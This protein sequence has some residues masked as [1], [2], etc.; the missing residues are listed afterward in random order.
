MNPTELVHAFLDRLAD[1]EIDRW[2][3]LL[4]DDV[5]ADTPFAPDGSPKGFAGAEAV[6]R[7]FGDARE[8]MQALDFYDRVV[9]ETTDGPVVV[10]CKSTGTRGD[11]QPYKN[12]YCW[13]FSIDTSKITGW[14]EYFDPQEVMRVRNPS[15]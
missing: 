8:R 2:M 15:A 14:V 11:G 13:L 10:T 5:R 3:D 1:G 12:T 7:R 6:R 4:S 9:H